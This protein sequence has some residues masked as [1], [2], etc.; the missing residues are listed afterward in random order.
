MVW[1]STPAGTPQPTAGVKLAP[2]LS[3]NEDKLHTPANSETKV[4][5]VVESVKRIG[6]S[7][8]TEVIGLTFTQVAVGGLVGLIVTWSVSRTAWNRIL[9]VFQSAP[10][11]GSPALPAVPP[12]GVK[13][14]YVGVWATTGIETERIA[15]TIQK[16]LVLMFKG[17]LLL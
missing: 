2:S 8:A 5:P 3:L 14:W 17:V 13:F 15:K 10:I 4:R 1:W 6:S 16:Q 7:V 9:P 12:G 11:E